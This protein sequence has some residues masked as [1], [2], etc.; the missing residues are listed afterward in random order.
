M[1]GAEMGINARGVVI[2]NEAV[3]SRWKPA[4]DGVLGMD[5]L[6]LALEKAEGG[7]FRAADEKTLSVSHRRQSGD[8]SE[9]VMVTRH[10]RFADLDRRRSDPKVVIA[11]SA[12][13]GT[14]DAGDCSKSSA[15]GPRNLD[16]FVRSDQFLQLGCC[17]IVVALGQ[18]P[19][20]D[21]ADS[22]CL[23]MVAGKKLHC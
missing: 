22:H 6:R 16:D 10:Q 3:F 17:R 14:K 13:R 23:R 5:I 7:E 18:F 12:A 8:P 4:R 11:Q 20:R 15:N 2:G 21:D 9:M 1:R 19:E